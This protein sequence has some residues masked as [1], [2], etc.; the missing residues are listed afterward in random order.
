MHAFLW[1]PLFITIS[2]CN[3]KV[4]LPPDPTPHT[5]VFHAHQHQSPIIG[6]L[7]G[8]LLTD[9]ATTPPPPRL[10]S[11]H[12]VIGLGLENVSKKKNV[13]PLRRAGEGST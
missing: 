12:I 2:K 9:S 10:P 5:L 7:N 3:S 8:Y 6:M 11:H 4:I 13:H 1:H